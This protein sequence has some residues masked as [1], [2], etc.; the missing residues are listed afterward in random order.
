[1]YWHR[2]SR[3]AYRQARYEIS[4]VSDP[5]LVRRV[6]NTVRLYDR[7]NSTFNKLLDHRRAY[8][9]PAEPRIDRTDNKKQAKQ[10][11]QTKQ[12]Q[13]TQQTKRSVEVAKRSK[14]FNDVSL[15]LHKLS[16][17]ERRQLRLKLV[18]LDA[19]GTKPAVAEPD[20][21]TDWLIEGLLAELRSRG[22]LIHIP[23]HDD[24]KRYNRDYRLQSKLVRDL[25]LEHDKCRLSGAHKLALGREIGRLLIKHTGSVDWEFLITKLAKTMQYVDRSFPGYRQAGMLGLIV[26]AEIVEGE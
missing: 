9:V 22:W 25:L 18:A 12:V 6:D 11:K 15:M 10:A 24:L 16:K 3:G 20:L 1:M 5:W 7:S 4:S 13:Q 21:A 2:V 8:C 17:D 23:R 14:Y 19:D 26:G